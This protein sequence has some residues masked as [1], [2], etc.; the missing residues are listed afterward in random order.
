MDR[1]DNLVKD[2]RSLQCLDFLRKG[3][4]RFAVSVGPA[5]TFGG[6]ARALES[7]DALPMELPLS[8]RPMAES[9]SGAC[10]F[11]MAFSA[12]F[13]AIMTCTFQLVGGWMPK[14]A[15]MTV[16]QRLL[17]VQTKEVLQLRAEVVAVSKRVGVGLHLSGWFL[18]LRPRSTDF[19]KLAPELVVK[20]TLP[21]WRFGIPLICLQPLV[22]F[23]ESTTFEERLQGALGELRL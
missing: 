20:N 13:R 1:L 9:L 18:D 6:C 22:A 10:L 12:L 15:Q 16:W 2:L 7:L 19:S 21:L 3:L 17:A 11:G 8:I 5:Q 23:Y 14:A 4:L